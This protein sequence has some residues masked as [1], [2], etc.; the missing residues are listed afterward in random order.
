MKRNTVAHLLL[1][2]HPT[3]RLPCKL[4]VQKL[5]T[6]VV[7]RPAGHLEAHKM[8]PSHQQCR[9][10]RHCMKTNEK[11]IKLGQV[12]FKSNLRWIVNTI[13]ERCSPVEHFMEIRDIFLCY[14]SSL[15]KILCVH[16]CI[17]A[18]KPV[19]PAFF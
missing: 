15:F 18:S 9:F 11:L 16:P 4:S 5:Q 1:L 10:Q 12:L 3:S 6:L 13:V 7:C 14:C 8:L 17:K 2:I 19:F